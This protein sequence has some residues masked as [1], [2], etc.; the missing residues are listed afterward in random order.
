MKDAIARTGA[1]GALGFAALFLVQN[2]V[3]GATV[4]PGRLTPLARGRSF[5]SSS[6]A[7]PL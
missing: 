5:T 2:V 1:L 6:R 4:P 7:T 3:R